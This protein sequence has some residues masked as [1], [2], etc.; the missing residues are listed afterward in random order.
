VKIL[1]WVL[2]SIGAIIIAICL[3]LVAVAILPG[4]EVPD[5]PLGKAKRAVQIP[6][7]EPPVSRKEV[8]FNV[9]GIEIK[10]WL[11][12]PQGV[13]E[14]L[15]C[16]VMASGLG[17]TKD[18]GEGYAVRFQETGFAVPELEEWRASGISFFSIQF[19]DNKINVHAPALWKN[20]KFELRGPT[21]RP[22]CGD[23]C[24]VWSGTLGEL[25]EA[26]S[27]AG[28]EIVEGPV[29]RVGGRE[30]GRAKGMSIYTRDPDRNLLEFIIY[31]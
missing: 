30:G 8:S 21:A 26:L 14:R 12:V 17:G 6:R 18:M 22:G 4:F 3:Y 29:E 15:P 28:A 1:T 13:S 16:I 31:S 9:K 23:F 7:A 11:Y 25:K 5:Q 19:G 24:F 2:L 27:R 20:S 10:A